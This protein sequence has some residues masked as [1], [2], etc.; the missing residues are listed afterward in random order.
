[1]GKREAN[2]VAANLQRWAKKAAKMKTTM[3]M[4]IMMMMTRMV[5]MIV[6]MMMT[7]MVMIIVRQCHYAPESG[8]GDCGDHFVNMA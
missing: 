4:V 7:T 8:D 1:M 3:N 6:T 5:M 2:D